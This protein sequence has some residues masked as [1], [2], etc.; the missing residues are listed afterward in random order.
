MGCARFGLCIDSGLS[1]FGNSCHNYAFQH[2]AFEFDIPLVRAFVGDCFGLCFW[3][4]CPIRESVDIHRP[5]HISQSDACRFDEW[6]C[7]V[8]QMEGGNFDSGSAIGDLAF[9]SFCMVPA[10][11]DYNV[12]IRTCSYIHRY[13]PRT[14]M[15]HQIYYNQ[16]SSKLNHS[17]V[18]SRMDRKNRRRRSHRQ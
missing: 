16:K 4:A 17:A 5:A 12:A 1:S 13:P 14:E 11:A 8:Q 2:R 9:S 6:P 10:N 3:L 7:L 18:V 15:D